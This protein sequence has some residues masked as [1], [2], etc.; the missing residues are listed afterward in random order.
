VQQPPPPAGD[1]GATQRTIG[2]VGGG[3]GVAALGAGAVLGLLASKAASDYQKHCGS[4]IGAPA[5]FCD[6]QGISGHDDAASKGTLST[7][8]FIG[9][10]VAAAAGLTVFLLAPKAAGSPTVGIGPGSVFVRA[11]F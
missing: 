1:P 5:G 11:R 7:I 6:A 10:G 4:S 9:G 8:F 2:L 3:V